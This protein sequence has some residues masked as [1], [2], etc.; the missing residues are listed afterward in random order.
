MATET[1]RDDRSHGG[2][3][4]H[5]DADQRR[6]DRFGHSPSAVSASLTGMS[7]TRGITAASGRT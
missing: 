7:P 4:H 3:D 5:D 6:H 1:Y 2:D